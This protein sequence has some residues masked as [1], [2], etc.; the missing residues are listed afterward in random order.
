VATAGEVGEEVRAMQPESSAG[1]TGADQAAGA[2]GATVLV[3]DERPVFRAGIRA[4]LSASPNG[5]VAAAIGP[6]LDGSPGR[7][8]DLVEEHHPDVIVV[9]LRQDDPTPFRVIATA[10]ALR[11][12]VRVLTLIDDVTGSELREAVVAGADGFLVTTAPLAELRRGVV[13]TARGERVVSPEVALHLAGAWRPDSERSPHAS[14]TPRELEVLELLAEGLT[15]AQIAERLKVSPRTVKTHVQN[16][17]SKLDT[18]DRTG[19]VARA[20]RLGII[21]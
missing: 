16:L 18:R 9:A 2:E 14:I 20:F 3:L 21:T 17:L 13:S 19:A 8:A 7:V 5:D 4:A 6:V 10:K 11:E 1:D 12:G 15:N